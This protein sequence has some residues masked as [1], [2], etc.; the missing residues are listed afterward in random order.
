MDH[1][2]SESCLKRFAAGQTSPAENRSLVIHLLKGC[3]HCTRTL[4]GLMSPEIPAGAYDAVF[5][6]VERSLVDTLQS[7]SGE[8]KAVMAGVR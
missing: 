2:I 3:G 5:A 8:R 1:P 4:N 6:R 7:F